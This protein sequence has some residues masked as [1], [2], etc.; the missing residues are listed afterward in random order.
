MHRPLARL[1]LTFSALSLPLLA[2]TLAHA[3]SFHPAHHTITYPITG[4]TGIALYRSI[5]ARGPT[6]AGHRT[7]AHTRFDL[8]W[9]RDYRPQADGGCVLAVAVPHLTITTTVPEGPAK[10]P[11][12]VKVSWARFSDGIR[13]H[14]RV[15]ADAIAAMVERIAAFSTGLSAPADPGC[16]KVRAKLQG[17]LAATIAAHKAESRAFDKQDW[18][19]GG[20]MKALVLDLVNGP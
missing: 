1:A 11:P 10:L 16:Q 9:R 2:T 18:S 19:D 15:H 8:T 3:A 7:I 5:G 17:F 6:V 13:A 20:H 12:A 14:E 4:T